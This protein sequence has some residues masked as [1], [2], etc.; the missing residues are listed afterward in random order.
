MIVLGRVTAPYGVAGWVRVRPF[1]DD[2]LGWRTIP[3]WWLSADPDASPDVW[4]GVKQLGCRLHGDGLVVQFEGANDR[5]A[6]ESLKGLF[7]GVPRDALPKTRKDEY[8]W[9]DLIGLPVVNSQGDSLGVV[10]SLIESG[11]N[12][13]LQLRDAEGVERLIPFTAQVVKK[14]Q[15]RN[16]GEG[17]V[18]IAVEWG[19]DW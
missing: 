16:P 6:A 11:A 19:R 17:D 15:V 12:T 1:G 4:R 8:Y 7:I 3:Q 18:G 5:N 10:E 14:V 2:P 13:V 9:T